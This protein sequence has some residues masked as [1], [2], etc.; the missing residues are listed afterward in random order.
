VEAR[1]AALERVAGTRL[2]ETR[3]EGARRRRAE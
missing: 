3:P 1:V 2:A